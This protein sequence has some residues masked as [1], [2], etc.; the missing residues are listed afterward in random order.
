MTQ[1]LLQV[2]D[3]KIAFRD[4][5]Q[6][7]NVV[8]G[9]SFDLHK[10]KTLALVGESGSGKSITALS[11]LQ[12]LP[13]PL[14]SHPGGK[15]LFEG[16]DILAFSKKQLRNLRRHK[17]SVIFQE[18]MSALNPLHTI[19]RQLTESLDAPPKTSSDFLQQECLKLLSMVGFDN[20]EKR[21]EAF[22][23]ELSGGQR[24]RVMIAMA[25]ASRPDL[26]IAD[27]PTTAVD[28]TTQ[29]Q[30]IQLLSSLQKKLGMSLLLISHDLALVHKISDHVAIM[31]EGRLVES[32]ATPEIF[33]NPRHTYTQRLLTAEPEGKAVNISGTKASQ[34]S[35]PIL[36][37]KKLCVSFPIKKGFLQ[38][39][40]D[41]VHAVQ[42]ASL[43]L[44]KGKTLGIVGESGS[45]KTT[46]AMAILR[47]QKSTGPIYLSGTPIENLKSRQLRPLRQRL[48]IVFQDPF[49]SL[50]P[51]M[52]LSQ[53]VM[54]GLY[55]HF[56]DI[57]ENEKEDRLI[58]VLKRVGLDPL[59]RDR[60]PHEFSGGQRQRISIARALILKPDI[61]IL[62]EPTSALDR[63]IQKDVLTLLKN[64]QRDEGLSYIFISHDLKVVRSISHD[65]IVMKQGRILEKGPTEDIFMAPQNPY[66][67]SLL[68]AALHFEVAPHE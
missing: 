63:V 30:I 26:L 23:H 19:E 7:R 37:T 34:N 17:V 5:K 13:Y 65:V 4:G 41:W 44:E 56:P 24:Q 55:V 42:D 27:E 12:L 28:V 6:N 64:L 66:T 60:Y 46:L 22:P 11:I 68:K 36:E 20:C 15:I 21:L 67:Q 9:V 58:D 14:A 16:Q 29:A 38:R 33:K 32:G 47:L 25:L 8:H 3:L 43:I 61:L 40:V 10:G 50:S 51:R 1:P 45:G 48:Q 49:G 57:T 52:T 39:T 62:D 53:I 54:E 35:V 2:Q 18:P 31:K 59:A